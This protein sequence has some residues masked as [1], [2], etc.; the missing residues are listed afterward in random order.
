MDRG[1]KLTRRGQNQ[2]VSFDPG[3][4][5]DGGVILACYTGV[6]LSFL[7]PMLTSS[8]QNHGNGTAPGDHS[9][10]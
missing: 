5:L 10:P 2:L 3:V 1:S 9:M 7:E 6:P 4:K 8:R